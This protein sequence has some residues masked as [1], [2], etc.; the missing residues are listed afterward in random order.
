MR[1]FKPE[2]L[3]DL[4]VIIGW[5]AIY[6]L[7]DEYGISKYEVTKYYFG[8]QFPKMIGRVKMEYQ[9]RKRDAHWSYVWDRNQ[10]VEWLNSDKTL[11]CNNCRKMRNEIEAL[12]N[13]ISTLQSHSS[14]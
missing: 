10:V 9:G 13:I 14:R 8:N 4:S 1:D 6:A 5:R 7:A 2:E 12:K 11:T 3:H